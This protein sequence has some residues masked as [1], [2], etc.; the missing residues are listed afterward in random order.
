MYM[1]SLKKQMPP[2]PSFE[3]IKYTKK[4]LLHLSKSSLAQIIPDCFLPN[5]Y[6]GEV[7]LRNSKKYDL[8]K[9]SYHKK[10][11]DLNHGD[12]NEDLNIDAR[13]EHA[14]YKENIN[15]KF[16]GPFKGRKIAHTHENNFHNDNHPYY[17]FGNKNFYKPSDNL[18]QK[19]PNENI[20]KNETFQNKSE[21]YLLT[22]YG[23]ISHNVDVTCGKN[24]YQ[25]TL[26]NKDDREQ[27]PKNYKDEVLKTAQRQEETLEKTNQDS[28]YDV[29]KT[30]SKNYSN[31]RNN[32]NK[33][34]Y[35]NNSS[36][37]PEWFTEGPSTHL[38]KIELQ[39]FEEMPNK[40]TN[41]P[42]KSISKLSN[43]LQNLPDKSK[44]DESNLN[45]PK[46]YNN[47]LYKKETNVKIEQNFEFGS[48]LEDQ[49]AN[50]FQFEKDTP[51]LNASDDLQKDI[52][53]MLGM[54]KN[55]S[56]FQALFQKS[57]SSN[58][59][60]N[61]LQSH[62]NIQPITIEKSNQENKISASIF[63][64]LLNFLPND[65]AI[66]M[67]D[68]QH[69]M[70]NQYNQ[71]SSISLGDLIP[72]CSSP[73]NEKKGKDVDLRLSFL[74]TPRFDLTPIQMEEK[75]LTPFEKLVLAVQNQEV[76]TQLSVRSPQD[77]QEMIT[78]EDILKDLEQCKI[79]GGNANKNNQYN[80][81]SYGLFDF[82]FQQG[83]NVKK[84]DDTRFNLAP[85]LF[86]PS[87]A[88][89]PLHHLQTSL[90]PT[91][92]IKNVVDH[93]YSCNGGNR[94][95]HPPPPSALP[96][97]FLNS[98]NHAY[99]VRMLAI[100]AAAA[101]MANPHPLSNPLAALFAP[102]SHHLLG[103]P[104]LLGPGQGSLQEDKGDRHNDAAKPKNNHNSNKSLIE[105]ASPFTPTAVFRHMVSNNVL[106]DNIKSKRNDFDSKTQQQNPANQ[107]S[108][109]EERH[110]INNLNNIFGF[111][112]N[113]MPNKFDQSQPHDVSALFSKPNFNND[114][115]K[116]A[117]THMM[118]MIQQRQFAM[119]NMLR[120]MNIGTFFPNNNE[121]PQ[122]SPQH[123][124]M[125]QSQYMALV[126]LLQNSNQ[127][128]PQQYTLLQNYFSQFQA[129]IMA[130][131][132]Q[133]YFISNILN[134][135]NKNVNMKFQQADQNFLDPVSGISHNFV[136]STSNN[137]ISTKS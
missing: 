129:A 81:A 20:N 10:S 90:D 64:N 71:A 14:R 39:G 50:K 135:L 107:L 66:I 134:N 72:N 11:Y 57:V 35:G 97:G 106:P 112:N 33:R 26:N 100:S 99:R 70:W 5:N 51:D 28:F 29:E 117:S 37:E 25:S 3:R 60:T 18:Y 76:N 67:S 115:T 74:N 84:E 121:I 2:Y 1:N 79:D 123:I 15:D 132:L 7:P 82:N 38:E 41:I 102:P 44:S 86:L 31:E 96:P 137:D 89:P 104:N 21:E 113:I 48:P 52:N 125:L 56:R 68:N 42:D 19:N 9:P 65:D 101:A 109:S 45:H 128:S 80:P 73:R 47:D 16:N 53:A 49:L 58:A 40:P 34:Y 118:N 55:F 59:E 105:K 133:R 69:D 36:N 22:N 91:A 43:P 103:P 12:Y 116:N 126:N 120:S 131:G 93:F 4:E 17:R 13:H 62:D 95:A 124:V 77:T 75:S 130:S 30:Y 111:P 136:K 119:L 94:F 61:K 78:E 122:L 32:F 83:M 63:N 114:M 6:N 46:K 24:L 127:L 54:G 27:Y 98:A 88:P 110:N 108:S 92:A 87:H 8:F 85:P 23:N